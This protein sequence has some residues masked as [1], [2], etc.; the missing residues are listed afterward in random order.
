MSILKG[1]VGFFD[2]GIGGLNVLFA[3]QPVLSR[4]PV[5]YYGDN[6]NAPYGN[7]SREELAPLIYKAFD[8]FAALEVQAVVIACN[9]V[10][11]LFID[12]LSTRYPFPILGV[13]P[14]V[15]RAAEQGGEI[16][17]L[18]T[19]AT[20]NS[21][22]MHALVRETE[23]EFS[24][25]AIRLVACPLLAGEIENHILE[26]GYDF[27]PFFP[28]GNPN[29]V[30]LGCTHYTYLKKEIEDFYGCASYDGK[31]EAAKNLLQI[32]PF[33]DPKTPSFSPRKQRASL[34]RKC[35]LK[36]PVFSTKFTLKKTQKMQKV[37]SSQPLYFLGSGRFYNAQFYKQMFVFKTNGRKVGKNSQKKPIF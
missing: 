3:C 27:T 10:T 6:A 8:L 1:G 24:E 20:I 34:R 2:S 7:K 4:L 26:Q 18:A 9:T 30:V 28:K 15:R 19:T 16:F 21:A 31:D 32:L 13:V 11:A 22:R 37:N 5:Y 29:S 36:T 25:A 35:P 12:E 33:F 17:T 14:A 23:T